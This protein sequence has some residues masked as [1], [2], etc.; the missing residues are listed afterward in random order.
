MEE[1]GLAR[2]TIMN[3]VSVYL[4]RQKGVGSLTERMSLRPFLGVLH[5][6]FNIYEVTKCILLLLQDKKCVCEMRS[7][8]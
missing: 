8:D 7:F 5:Q 2:F 1:E 4:G 6:S 3:D